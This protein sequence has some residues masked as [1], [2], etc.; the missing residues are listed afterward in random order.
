[1][2]Y[3]LTDA[4]ATYGLIDDPKIPLS[5]TL[6]GGAVPEVP[7]EGL[8]AKVSPVQT[9]VGGAVVGALIGAGAVLS[10]KL[11]KETIDE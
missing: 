1:M 2:M 9:A 6:T 11:S 10:S 5:I 8:G 7:T 3:I 4:P